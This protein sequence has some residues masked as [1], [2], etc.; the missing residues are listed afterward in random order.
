MT[1]RDFIERYGV[2]L[3]IL[4][5]LA[6]VIAIL[7]GNAVERT[8]GT[9]TEGGT[10]AVEDG[11]GTFAAPGEQP[12]GVAPD[13]SVREIRDGSRVPGTEAPGGGTDG[14]IAP[15]GGSA[16]KA[17][18]GKGLCRP[19]DGRQAGVGR[20]MPPCSILQ[21]SNG[22]ATS[23]GVA[24]DRITIVRYVGQ[25]DPG[26]A[27]ILESARLRDPEDVKQVGYEG[28]R[29]YGNQHYNT[30]GRE[31]VFRVVNASGRGD[32]DEAMKADA[33]KIANDIKA[34]G[35]IDGAPDAP[36]P[37]ILAREL[38]QRGVVCICTTSLTSRFY[39]ES[40]PYT[41]GSGLPTA[42]EYAIQV[43]EYIGKRLNG[44]KAIWAGD[45]VFPAQQYRSKTR[46][47]GLIYIEGS[48]GRVDPEGRRSKDLFV[49]ELRRHGV[50]LDSIQGYIYEGG[51]NQQDVSTLIAAMRSKGITTV[52]MW[53]DPLYPIF[54]TQEATR[55]RWYPEW[56]I[57]GSGLSDTTAAGRLYDQVQWRH[58]FGVSPLWVT[59]E[60]K[61]NSG[62]HR[63]FLH[64][65]PGA[66]LDDGGILIDIYAAFVGTMFNGIHMAGPNLTPDSFAA[67]MFRFPRTGG[68]AAAPLVY[69]T[70]QYPTAI[71]DF[72]EVW[73]DLDR[74][75]PDE[76]GDQGTGMIMK[77]NRGKRY[78]P[79]QWPT[80]QPK[81]FVQ[82]GS[83][84][85]VSD[86]PPG[87]PEPKHEQDGHTHSGKCMSCPGA[88]T[89]K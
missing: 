88:K 81:A 10:S 1:G 47:F 41:F 74:R 83:E 24:R 65:M 5:L 21:G 23:R 15:V 79:G 26:T 72:T 30:Y 87:P 28:L 54:L 32:N 17:V 60:N 49:R 34:F 3:A 50:K 46:K 16:G 67:G 20:T 59:W 37:P 51:R 75:G 89:N 2:T 44:R 12:G 6:L 27:A 9:F 69:W 13:G 48:S 31:V 39:N 55:Q 33:V 80:T 36:I 29:R 25:Q 61:R 62:G 58:A 53:A 57:T 82:D 78:R 70:R 77:M 38:A 4:G 8:A 85:A 35:V 56:F 40:P 43:G 7:P 64:G 14:P 84:L 42:D 86:K 68:Y 76:R 19:E 11:E 45:E 73:Y 66:G 22:G 71:K 18:F 63:A 52:L